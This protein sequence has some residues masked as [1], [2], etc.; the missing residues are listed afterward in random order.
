MESD[1]SSGIGPISPINLSIPL[2][3][4]SGGKWYDLAGKAKAW[5]R[6]GSVASSLGAGGVDPQLQLEGAKDLSYRDGNEEQ[7]EEEEE[8]ED[9]IDFDRI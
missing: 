7:E 6:R 2:P 8:E 3:E 4:E 1:S 9:Y 5:S